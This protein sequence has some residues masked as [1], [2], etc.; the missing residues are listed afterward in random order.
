VTLRLAW[1]AS[2]RGISS[3]L[4]FE[5]TQEA[6]V[7]GRLDAEI[8][9]VFCNRVRGQSKNTDAFLETVVAS[10]IPLVT[11]SSGDWRKRVGGAVSDPHS[12]LASWRLDYDRAVRTAIAPYHPD[13]GFLAG[14]MLITTTELCDHFPLLNLHP[15]APGGPIGAWK[16][17]IRTLIDQRAASSG[18]MLQRATTKLDEGP[19]VTAC[20]YA[21]RDGLLAP[22]W[23]EQS[24]TDDDSE[25]SEL[26][27]AIRAEG[28][29]REPHFI[30]ASLAAL[31]SGRVTVP[32]Q[33][34]EGPALDLTADVEATLAI[35]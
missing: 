9:V 22:M 28:V 3:R 10:N 11:I 14:Y 27:K 1:F 2:A 31:A 16:E 33:D 24:S 18:I 35:G 34:A 25:G 12:D 13:V 30:L 7:N 21:L 26:F 8:V 23:D 6:I 4:L 32:E 29:K 5:R 17:V 20:R 15:A 19:I